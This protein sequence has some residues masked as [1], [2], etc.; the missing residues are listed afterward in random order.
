MEIYKYNF[1]YL[2]NSDLWQVY[3]TINVIYKV[4]FSFFLRP[5][6]FQ[7]GLRQN[8]IF[9]LFLKAMVISFFIFVLVYDFSNFRTYSALLILFKSVPHLP[10]RQPMFLFYQKKRNLLCHQFFFYCK[11]LD[12]QT[13]RNTYIKRT[14]ITNA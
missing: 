1:L 3:Q 12:R 13:Y 14:R 6:S 8:Y 4:V 11:A 9:M 7:S 5:Q 2:T 10:A